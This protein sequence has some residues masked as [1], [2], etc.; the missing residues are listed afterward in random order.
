VVTTP[1]LW[2]MRERDAALPATV[3]RTDRRQQPLEPI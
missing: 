1:A 3:L 2:S